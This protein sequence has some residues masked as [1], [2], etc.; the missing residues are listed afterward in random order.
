M[1]AFRATVAKLVNP[2]WVIDAD[3]DPFVSRDAWLDYMRFQPEIGIPCLYSLTHMSFR[4]G[5]AP[6]EPIQPEDLAEIR[7]IWEQYLAG[8]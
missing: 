1:M 5:H 4:Q 6:A 2:Q 3:N 7:E 8:K